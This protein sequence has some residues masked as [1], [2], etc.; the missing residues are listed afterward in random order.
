MVNT[1]MRTKTKLTIV[2]TEE[3]RDAINRAINTD[4][5]GKTLSLLV[6]ES[7]KQYVKSRGGDWPDSELKWGGNRQT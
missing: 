4:P 1:A 6:R 7:L 5:S 2:V 3:Q